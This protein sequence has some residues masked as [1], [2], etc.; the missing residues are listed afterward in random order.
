MIDDV[1]INHNII[2][3]S[4]DAEFFESRKLYVQQVGEFTNAYPH[5]FTVD[6][7]IK[8]FIEKYK[9]TLNLELQNQKCEDMV[10]LAGRVSVKRSSGNKIFF[11]EL[12]NYD[13]NI[14]VIAMFNNYEYKDLDKFKSIL[15]NIKRGDIIGIKGFAGTSNTKEFSVF[16]TD[17]VILSPC[18]HMLPDEKV[19]LENKEIRYRQRHLDLIMNKQNIN[20]FVTRSKIIKYIRNFFD[21]NNFTE[22]ETPM[23]NAI[24]GGANARP[25]ITYHNCLEQDM[26]MRIAPE[27][28]LKMLVVGG[29]ERVYELGKQFRNEDIDLTHNPEFTSIEAYQA[30]ADYNDMMK[31]TEDLLSGLAMHLYGKTQ[32]E[33][34]PKGGE[35]LTFNFAGPYKKLYI[36]PELET[37]L[38]IKFPENFS[39]EEFNLWLQQ[40]CKDNKVDCKAPLTTPRLFDALISEFLEPECVQ[41]TFI[42]DHPRIMSPLAK[43]NRGDLRLTERFELFVNKKELCNSYTELNNPFVQRQEFEN[44]MK[45]KNKGDD[46]AMQLDEGFLNALEY[47]LPPTAGWGLGIDRLI[48]FMTNNNSIKE[49]M[50]FPAMR[51]N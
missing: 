32:I 6:M 18:L 10:K 37:R 45:D 13:C 35:S 41:P 30:F 50:L 15:N 3:M 48:M 1:I 29:M 9:P 36:I 26:F 33:Y 40:I 49:V 39:T 46:E 20:I 24:A 22:V 12:A 42:C 14:Q 43:W 8:D 5:K 28:Y 17:V 19:G 47:G 4:G 7:R 31:M 25:F 51:K 44:Q 11:I 34:A 2:K 38:N 16:A 23:M 27:L 21:N